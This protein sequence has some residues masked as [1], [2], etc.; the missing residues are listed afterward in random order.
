MVLNMFHTL[1]RTTS[2]KG[3]CYLNGNF[4]LFVLL[5]SVQQLFLTDVSRQ[6]LKLEL[7][8]FLEMSVRN[9]HNTLCNNTDVRSSHLLRG[10]SLNSCCINDLNM[11]LVQNVTILTANHL[12]IWSRVLPEEITDSQLARKFTVFY[13]T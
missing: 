7:L 11:G 1:N 8:C 6:P 12:S 4:S 3:K 9:Y 2:D 5:R 13:G 10:G